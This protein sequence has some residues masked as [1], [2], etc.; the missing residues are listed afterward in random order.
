MDTVTVV[1][2][3]KSC[4]KKKPKQTNKPSVFHCYLKVTICINFVS[5][6]FISLLFLCVFVLRKKSKLI[7]HFK[8]RRKL[9]RAFSLLAKQR[10]GTAH[11]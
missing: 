1:A 11:L 3:V 10:V 9:Y 8:K 5:H 7:L 2:I 6:M 4:T